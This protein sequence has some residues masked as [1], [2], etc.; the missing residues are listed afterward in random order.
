[1]QNRRNLLARFS[2]STSSVEGRAFV[3]QR[4]VLFI[5]MMFWSFVALLGFINVMYAIYPVTRPAQ[6][7]IINYFAALGLVV[8]GAAFFVARRGRPH[9][10]AMLVGIDVAAIVV[11][12]TAFTASGILS[13]DRVA[14]V[15]SSFIW[16]NFVVFARVLVIPSTGLRTLLLSSVG[17]APMLIV[18]V[19]VPM[20]TPVPAFVVGTGIFCVVAVVLSTIGSRV[21][22]GLRTQVHE[23][24]QLGQYTIQERI[25]EGGMGTVYR[26]R[27]ALL[28]RPTA[29][30]ILR[31]ERTS[32][33]NQKR[34][35]R[36]VQ[37]TAEL[38]HPNTVAIFDYGLSPDGM[39]YYAMEYLDGVD[40]S[41]LVKQDGAQ[42]WSRVVHILAQVCGALQEAHGRG[43]IHRDIKPSNIIL[44]TRGGIPDVAKVVD[45]GLVK[46]LEDDEEL[47]LGDV[48][49]GTPT[50]LAPEAVT[51]P[52]TVG[53]A[54][55]L[56]G[57][58]CVG[59]FLLTGKT[60]FTGRTVPELCMHH[61]DTE[62]TPPSKRTDNPI[63]DQFERLILQCLAKDPSDR[64]ESAA[65][66][67]AALDELAGDWTAD[68]ARDWWS[69]FQVQKD[70]K[71]PETE[72][73]SIVTMTVDIYGRTE[74]DTATPR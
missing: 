51:D 4:T 34:F 41:T 17:L 36:E 56:Y 57:L 12:T 6:A 27:H 35:E 33:E 9:S 18:A 65:A 29:I 64:V 63:P 40:L 50:Y 74:I 3:Q 39:F 19:V 24:M 68:K 25:G 38:T 16:V 72:P 43:L 23:A 55:D 31:P 2:P 60:V 61:V 53:P 58:A 11:I 73:T 32:H 13:A 10:A 15:Y 48:I 71:R 37:I 54:S 44:C 47:S 69:R 70:V 28:R 1:M 8:L 21:I 14:N 42:E 62:P 30:K 7:T 22:Y 59:Y 26:A 5:K 49:A 46:E 45:F 20:E 67:Q 52:Q 66:L